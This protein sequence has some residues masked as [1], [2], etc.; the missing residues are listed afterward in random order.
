MDGQL[1]LLVAFTAGTIIGGGLMWAGLRSSSRAVRKKK[2]KGPS[3]PIVPGVDRFYEPAHPSA[4][5]SP[6]AE[7]TPLQKSPAEDVVVKMEVLPGTSFTTKTTATVAGLLFLLALAYKFFGVVSGGE[8]KALRPETQPPDIN[9]NINVTDEIRSWLDAAV[10]VDSG[11]YRIARSPRQDLVE[12]LAGTWYEVDLRKAD[13][14]ESLLFLPGNYEQREYESRFRDVMG[15]VQR[16][17]LRPGLNYRLFVRGN[18]DIVA[19]DEPFIDSLMNGQ[20]RTLS[21]LKKKA[22]DP[23]VYMNADSQQTVPVQYGNRHLPNLRGDY[24][25]QRLQDQNPRASVTLLDGNVTSEV[26]E[27]DRNAQI[28]LFLPRIARSP[29]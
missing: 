12:G 22:G 23:N 13:Q 20:P 5:P 4:L 24:I 9:I 19:N 27:E 25:R 21:F 11:D 6:S 17:V 3:H 1:G 18:A 15:R 29:R 10:V 16:E 8:G 7:G 28:F 2:K 26:N 14:E